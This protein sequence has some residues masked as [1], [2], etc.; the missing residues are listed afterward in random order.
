MNERISDELLAAYLDGNTSPIENLYV[1][2]S[3]SNDAEILEASDILSDMT[4]FSQID[5]FN[6]VFLDF[7]FSDIF[8]QPISIETNTYNEAMDS[9]GMV[10]DIQQQYPDSCAIK[11]Q[12]II[13]NEFGIDVNEDQLVKFSYEQGWYNADGTGTAA[14]DVGNLLET[15]NIPVTRQEDA[16]V[17]NLVSELSQGHKVI[18]G[19]D[20]EEL[21][22]NK[23]MAWLKD[24]FMGDTPDHAL[25]VAGIDTSD[26]NNVMVIVD[27]PGSG[28]YHKAYPLDQFMDAWSDAQCYMVSTD[29]P[30]P[31]YSAAM[32][33]FDYGQ[34]HI[35][36][37]GGMNYADFQIFNDLSYGLPAYSMVDGGY[38]SPT[39]SLMD[40]YFDMANNNLAFNDIFSDNYMFN[41]YLNTEVAT[42]M[43]QHTYQDNLN[44]INFNDMPNGIDYADLSSNQAYED[45]LH[46]SIDYFN[47]IG[48]FDSALLC[49]QQ[50]MMVDYCDNYD[51]DF[52]STFFG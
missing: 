19:V 49:Q 14:G 17:F 25:V 24:F 23:F 26:P 8:S 46:G 7:G 50:L 18:V 34:G 43:M 35:A 9:N 16:N 52:C 47:S 45:F 44:M 51:I 15:A 32:A 28:E 38:V 27:D 36:D 39:S 11:S 13:L 37:V 3:I 29:I 2:S 33:N 1:E 5:N 12:Q 30:V 48:D 10:P 4:M 21:W 22:G 40:A 42:Q 6:D 41:D 31:D 20:S